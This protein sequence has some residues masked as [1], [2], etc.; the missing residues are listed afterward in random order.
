MYCLE[1]KR[2]YKKLYYIAKTY[3]Y[4]CSLEQSYDKTKEILVVVIWKLY[5]SAWFVVI[6]YD[7]EYSYRTRI[8]SKQ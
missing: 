4:G 1:M 7:S 5:N 3:F 2:F 6:V 8:Y